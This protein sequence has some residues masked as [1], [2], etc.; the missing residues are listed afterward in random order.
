MRMIES[1]VNQI[2]DLQQISSASEEKLQN[3]RKVLFIYL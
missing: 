1:Q 3:V 2:K